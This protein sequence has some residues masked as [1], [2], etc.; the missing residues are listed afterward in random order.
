LRRF[1]L[2]RRRKGPAGVPGGA[3]E[4][5]RTLPIWEPISRGRRGPHDTSGARGN[6][7]GKR[8]T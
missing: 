4:S 8:L 3:G 1:L 7:R 5:P 6:D 2:E